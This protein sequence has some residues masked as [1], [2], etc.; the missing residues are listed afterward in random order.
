MWFSMYYLY[1][2]KKIIFILDSMRHGEAMYNILQG[3]LVE[4]IFWCCKL[5][6]VKYHFHDFQSYPEAIY[7]WYSFQKLKQHVIFHV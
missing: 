6:Q 7:I 5:L 3:L 2:I 1:Q 4:T